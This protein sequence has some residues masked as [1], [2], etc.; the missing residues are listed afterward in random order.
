MIMARIHKD[1]EINH[2]DSQ[3]KKWFAIYTKYKCE[4]FV[5]DLLGKKQIDAYVPL[6][7][8]VKRY[9]RKVKK[10][11]TPLINNYVFVNITTKDYIRTIETEYVFKFIRQGKNLISIP[12]D[13]ITILKKIVGDVED[14]RFVDSEILSVGEEVEVIAGR[15]VGLTGKIVTKLGKKSFV[16]ELKNIGYQFQVQIDLTL[17]RPLKTEKAA[18]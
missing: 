11:E 4:K 3:H 5:S 6:Q 10:Y 14:T 18:V 15:L 9:N 16:I 7:T 1:E 13:E 12:E 17:L 8:V 2:L